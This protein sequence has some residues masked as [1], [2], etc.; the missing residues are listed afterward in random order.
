VATKRRRQGKKNSAPQRTCLGCGRTDDQSALM[1]MVVREDGELEIGRFARGRGGYVH[2]AEICW[3][4]L[5][6]RKSVYRAFHEEVD[7][8]A[9]AR[10]VS[11]LR[12]RS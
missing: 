10:L 3:N 12:D 1:R 7:R 6:Q 4:L 5:A 8:A 9:R 2:A 11:R